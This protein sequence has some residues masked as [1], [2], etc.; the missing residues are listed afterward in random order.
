MWRLQ[1]ANKF[2]AQP[3]HSLDQLTAIA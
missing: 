1:K 3:L 2:L